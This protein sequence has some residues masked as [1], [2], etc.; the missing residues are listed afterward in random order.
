[1]GASQGSEAGASSQGSFSWSDD[2]VWE[3]VAAAE[4]AAS[5]SGAPAA[6][7]KN[8]PKDAP[9]HELRKDP[10]G[11]AAHYLSDAAYGAVGFGDFGTYM[12]NKR[13]KI[14]IQNA[15]LGASGASRVLDGCVI[16]ITG[17]TDPPYAELRRLILLH[18]G[19]V[20]PYL[21]HKR[22]VTHIVASTI[23]PKKCL[24]F[25]KY[26]VVHPG[27]VLES[28]RTGRL[29]DWTRWRVGDVARGHAP[30]FGAPCGAQSEDRPTASVELCG[31][32]ERSAAAH[33][34]PEQRPK[35]AAQLL[36]S[37]AWRARHTAASADFLAGY[38]ARSRLHHLST[39][40]ATLQDLVAAAAHEGG[41]AVARLPP[42]MPRVLFHVDFDSFFVSVGLRDRPALR[43]KPV[44]VCHAT[45]DARVTSSSEIASCNYA[46]RA[47]GVRNGMS[48]A[49]ARELCADVSTIPYTF[50]AYYAV[51]LQF[52]AVL[53]DVADALQVVSIDEA[54]LDVSHVVAALAAGDRA[55]PG[56]DRR[57]AAC[58]AAHAGLS[59]VRALA[60]A[61]RDLVRAETHCEVSVGAG[62]NVLQARLATRRAKPAGSFHLVPE[63]VD[64]FLCELDVRDVWG[65]GWSL[66]ERFRM[67][68]G[69]TN[70]GAI[71]ARASEAQLVAQFGPRQGRA[72]WDKLHGRDTGELAMARERRSVGTHVSW[73]VRLAD[74]A[75]VRAFVRKVCDEVAQRAARMCV[76]G[77]QVAVQLLERAPDAGEASKFLGHG[78]CVT[79]HRSLRRRVATPAAL[80]DAVWFLVQRLGVPPADVRGLGVSLSRFAQA[81]GVLSW[82][83][84]ADEAGSASE[85]G[86]AGELHARCAADEAATEP[87]SSPPSIS[88]ASWDL[89]PASQIDADVV[90]SLP[91]DIRA[92]IEAA[93]A[94]RDGSP[95]PAGTPF[96]AEVPSASQLDLE[97]VAGLPP[98]LRAQV[99][100]AV[101]AQR[102]R[103]VSPERCGPADLDP[104]VLAEIPAWLRDEV[105][106]EAR[107]PP[108][109]PRKPTSSS[110]PATPA[111]RSPASG[112]P[113]KR[114][115][116][117][118]RR[119]S[120]ASPRS[121]SKQPRLLAYFSPGPS[122]APA[123]SAA[124]LRALGIDAD[125]FRALPPAVQRDVLVER[126]ALRAPRAPHAARPER[127]AAAWRRAAAEEALAHEAHIRASAGTFPATDPVLVAASRARGEPWEPAASLVEAAAVPDGHLHAA[128]P[129]DELRAA[130]SRWHAAC[131]AA[132][133][134]AGDVAHVEGVLRACVARRALDKA[135]RLLAWWRALAAAPCT[136]V[137]WR[138]A[139]DRAAAAVQAIVER[140]LRAVLVVPE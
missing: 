97:V 66:A 71:R 95:T 69:T 53:L 59:P 118:K 74:E 62:A 120:S 132:V 65:V 67:W 2:A 36:A 92:R 109:T 14:Q 29:A 86:H 76:V 47:H 98:D 93:A 46:A 115:P 37:E 26:R 70:V 6:S 41:H 125:V 104:T 10:P 57:L 103:S 25:R 22:A 15:E 80:F 27:W 60:E 108:S 24:E 81:Q 39:W 96:R 23:T 131:G 72:L 52:Y 77:T 130:L 16:Y 64:D 61:L 75:E 73:G 84:A 79:H 49:H 11:D 139:Y 50:D 128:Q 55:Q 28:C 17:R 34:S 110:L 94:K 9:S 88:Q 30:L 134:A 102:G 18:G 31:S 111:S 56:R 78:A 116:P 133:P 32:E 113:S 119:A 54:L 89:P 63:A 40:K 13:A 112:S 124:E 58:V 105:L 136:H 51:S 1:M 83:H 68:L 126:R 122:R 21:D 8:V 7:P 85:A 20:M 127:T 106:R 5:S 4:A 90:A 107:P 138:G 135:A 42:G 137:A 100:A 43:D 12:R 101:A 91:A 99:E 87:G 123:T 44:V 38:Y 35:T 19:Q 48:L 114:T 45:R 82:A 33:S 140:E 129:L 117:G 121:P 3:A